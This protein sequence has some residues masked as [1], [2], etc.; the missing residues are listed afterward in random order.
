MSEGWNYL[1]ALVDWVCDNWKRPDVS[2]WQVL[3]KDPQQ[4]VYSKV[5]CWVA[6]DRALRIAEM[7]SFPFITPEESECC[8]TCNVTDTKVR[9]SVLC[10]FMFDLILMIPVYRTRR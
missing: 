8:E 4:Y 5:M 3:T 2:I 10:T 7:R 9:K 1:L 6:I